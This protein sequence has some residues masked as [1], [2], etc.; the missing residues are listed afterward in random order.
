MPTTD[1][2]YLAKVLGDIA[3]YLGNKLDEV[4]QATQKKG[5]AA[6]AVPTEWAISQNLADTLLRIGYFAKRSDAEFEI[7][8]QSITVDPN[9]TREIFWLPRTDR[10]LRIVGGITIV[11]DLHI[12]GLTATLKVDGEKQVFNA[13]LGY[14]LPLSAEFIPEARQEYRL[15]IANTST[16]TVN[17]SV[18]TVLAHVTS[19]FENRILLPIARRLYEQIVTLAGQ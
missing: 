11:P 19:D 18:D 1:S 14:D 12:A 13:D 3:V 16:S 4:V 17:V 8:R 10:V 2:E 6:P 5:T 7:V 15:A 9:E